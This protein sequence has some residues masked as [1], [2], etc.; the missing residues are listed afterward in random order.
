MVG[1]VRSS[2]E[3]ISERRHTLLGGDRAAS[4][5]TGSLGVLGS[6]AGGSAGVAVGAS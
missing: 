1:Q 4:T 3:G 5:A 6:P 2:V